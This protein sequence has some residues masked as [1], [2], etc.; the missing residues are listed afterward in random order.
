MDRSRAR[1]VAIPGRPVADNRRSPSDVAAGMDGK[2]SRRN[3]IQRRGGRDASLS[4]AGTPISFSP[5][6]STC[7][8]KCGVKGV[9]TCAI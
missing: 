8:R 4:R 1:S 2:S 5:R 9:V 7:G 6:S 3:V